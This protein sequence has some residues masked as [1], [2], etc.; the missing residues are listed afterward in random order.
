MELAAPFSSP[1]LKLVYITS[2]W[3]NP[4]GL[5]THMD[6][7]DVFKLSAGFAAALFLARDAVSISSA[8][9][10][11]SLPMGESTPFSEDV[12]IERARQLSQ[13]PYAPPE[14]TIP[15][16]YKD[17]NY[18]QYRAI[19]FKKDLALWRNDN[20]SFTVEF[21]STGYIY[22]TPVQIFGVDAGHAAELKY[23]PDLFTYG[24]EV[25]RPPDNTNPGFSG[26]RLHTLIN[27]PDIKD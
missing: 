10:L 17:L 6:R 8:E 12:V 11:A 1:K 22:L 7:R 21:F 18:D 27:R 20:L 14:D 4:G 16:S 23:H 5:S 2:F 26:F 25:S 13:A 3:K 24:P 9:S 19:R 15:A